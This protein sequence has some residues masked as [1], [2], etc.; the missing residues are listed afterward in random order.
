[1]ESKESKKSMEN[2]EQIYWQQDMADVLEVWGEGNAWHELLFLFSGLSGKV[3][4]IACGT[5]KN[6]LDLSYNTNLELHGCDISDLLISRA[7]AKGLSAARLTVCNATAMP[8]PKNFF[9]YCYSIG[10]LEHF[11][12]GDEVCMIRESARISR[13]AAFHMIPLSRSKCDEGWIEPYQGYYNNSKEWWMQRFEPEFKRIY[14]L[15]S[16]WKD[17]HSEGFWFICEK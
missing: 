5:G 12:D 17:A 1:M 16:L 8:F 14:V 6:M 13:V 9:D 4:D 10:S 15:P 11:R 2:H 3:L 7:A